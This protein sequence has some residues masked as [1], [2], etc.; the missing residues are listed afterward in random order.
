MG[1]HLEILDLDFPGKGDLA[2]DTVDGRQRCPTFHVVHLALDRV[3]RTQYG[4]RRGPIDHPQLAAVAPGIDTASQKLVLGQ[5][6]MRSAQV[7][8][9][10][11]GTHQRTSGP[12]GTDQAADLISTKQQIKIEALPH[13]IDA[14]ADCQLFGNLKAGS[15]GN[16][17]HQQAARIVEP[18]SQP[19]GSPGQEAAIAVLGTQSA[20]SKGADAEGPATEPFGVGRLGCHVGAAVVGVG[21]GRNAFAGCLV[22]DVDIGRHQIKANHGL[23]A[24]RHQRQRCRIGHHAGRADIMGDG[25]ATHAA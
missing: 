9:A 14:A 16:V 24:I 19:A 12:S 25:G 15:E 7:W 8:Q 17:Q 21:L 10:A 3:G 20:L 2:G 23:I 13:R 5:A 22:R 1:G 18:G 11:Q 4:F 6:E